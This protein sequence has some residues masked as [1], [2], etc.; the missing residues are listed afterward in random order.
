MEA[1]LRARINPDK[2]EAALKPLNDM[3][4]IRTNP[5][6][7]QL[8]ANTHQELMDLIFKEI[9]TELCLE[10]GSEYYAALR[11]QKD[12]K[13]WIHALKSDVNFTE[14]K[15]IWPIP[16]DEMINNKLM[17]QNPGLK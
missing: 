14:E 5:V 17:K 1:E 2:I 16:N 6:L 10:N 12:G 8:S 9:W 13:S 3:R 11:F 4:G 15:Y 7:P